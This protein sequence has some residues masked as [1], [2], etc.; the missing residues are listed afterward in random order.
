MDTSLV[1]L[2]LML[3][4]VQ[5]PAPAAPSP[6]ALLAG[7]KSI[8]CEFP[9]AVLTEWVN[10]EPQPKISRATTLKIAFD[11]IDTQE[12]SARAIY[13]TAGPEPI[14]A[15]LSGA[16]LHFVDI[17]PSGSLTI[18]TVFAQESHPM[19]LKAVYTQTDYLPIEIPGFA[20]A[21]EVSQRFGECQVVQPSNSE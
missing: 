21:P 1:V 15:Q 2:L 3:L 20:T 13:S 5:A 12:S 6:Q 14:V 18:T 8:S 10:G 19:K 16:N 4:G 11:Q 9:V 17:R 7:A